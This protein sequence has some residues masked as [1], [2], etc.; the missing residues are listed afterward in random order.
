MARLCS[1]EKDY[2][3]EVY[4][5]WDIYLHRGNPVGMLNSWIKD[6]YKNKWQSRVL[7][8]RQTDA[9]QEHLSLESEYNPVWSMIDLPRIFSTIPDA[10]KSSFPSLNDD[11]RLRT[12]LCRT[13]NFF[14]WVNAFNKSVL[15]VGE[16]S[17][18]EGTVETNLSSNEVWEYSVDGELSKADYL[19][20]NPD[21]LLNTDEWLHAVR[22]HQFLETTQW[23]SCWY[24]G[25]NN[26]NPN[27]NR[28][29]K[30]FARTGC[31]RYLLVSCS[32]MIM[33]TS[34]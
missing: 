21:R 29:G 17:F 2:K 22:L 9:E 32:H 26:P 7:R 6:N 4:Q 34:R 5:G 16:R 33:F 13:K 23:R 14:N 25:N 10:L 24:Y 3:I 27:P 30:L 28:K 12:S 31:L 8:E 15:A 19:R 1:Y 11:T 18:R 20:E